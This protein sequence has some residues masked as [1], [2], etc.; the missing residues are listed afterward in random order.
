ML[1]LL[2]TNLAY[3]YTRLDFNHRY[4]WDSKPQVVLCDDAKAKKEDVELAM[5]FWKQNMFGMHDKIVSKPCKKTHRKGEIRIT[6]QRDLDTK[7]YYAFTMRDT[8]SIEISAATILIEDTQS[9][10]LKLIIHELGHALGV[11]HTDSDDSHIM[12]KHVVDNHTRLN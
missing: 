9:N 12:H 8:S 3:S 5:K 2:L 7:K 1:F 4:V 10:N 6:G 11:N